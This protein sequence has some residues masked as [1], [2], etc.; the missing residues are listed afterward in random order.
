LYELPDGRFQIMG[1]GRVAPMMTGYEYVL[2][3][4]QLAAYF[5]ALD[6]PRPEI[7]DATIYDA[8]R[9]Q[10]ILT[11]RQLRIGQQFSCDMIRDIDLDGER[12]LLMDAR[13]VFVSPL[14][15]ER[16]KSS[17]FS[18]RRFTEGLGEFPG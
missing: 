4:Q 12:L 13:Y 14:L 2:V 9:K 8:R 17:Q 6:I 11:H 18:Y 5:A 1:A 10:E 16:L 7:I 3:E 15:C